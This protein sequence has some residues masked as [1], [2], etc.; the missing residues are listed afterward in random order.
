MTLHE[1]IAERHPAV[2]AWLD[3]LEQLGDDNPNCLCLDG[4]TPG[5]PQHPQESHGD[6][7]EPGGEVA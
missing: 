1:H 3:H 2:T 7:V 6:T 4:R 5:C